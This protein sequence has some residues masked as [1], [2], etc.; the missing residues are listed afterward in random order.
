MML[1]IRRSLPAVIAM[2]MW[3]T[4]FVFSPAVIAE[5]GAIQLTGARWFI[6]IV[7]LI[8]LAFALEKP[9]LETIRGEWK[10]HLVQSLLGYVGYTLLLYFALEMTSPVTAAVLVALNPATIAIAAHFLLND[11]LSRVALVGIAVSF[12]GAVVVVIGGQSLSEMSLGLGDVLLLLA[13]VVWTVYSM[14][15][16]RVKTPPI[17]ATTVQAVIAG[18]VMAPVMALDIFAGNT[19]WATLDSVG[20][21]G[22]IWIG[23]IPSAGAYFLW[24][25][26]SELIGP[27]RTG[28]F[29][30]LIPVFTAVLVVALGGSVTVWHLLGGALVLL[31]V[32]VTN[33][34]PAPEPATRA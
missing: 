4:N 22:V 1:N 31:G 8:P 21:I 19:G 10:T 26:S 23:L 30:N 32:S 33:R 20:W 3:A 5:V 25:I 15:A 29:L 18:L 16:P 27:S 12:I 14:V 34:R 17:T 24:N 11:R 9:K 6:A 7:I 2:L 28:A 13:T